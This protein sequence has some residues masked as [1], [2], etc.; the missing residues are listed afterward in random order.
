MSTL[1][2]LPFILAVLFVNT[3]ATAQNIGINT[4]GAVPAASSILDLVSADKGLLIP[5]VALTA[6]NAAAPVTAPATSLLVYNTA[7]AGGAPFNVTPGYYYWDGAQWLRVNAGGATGWTILGNAGTLPTTNFIGTTDAADWV[8][9][10]GGSAATNERARVVAG[11]QVV[12]NNTGLGLNTN[13][14]FSVYGSGTNNGVTLNTS[15]LGLRAINGYTSAGGAAAAWGV[16]GTTSGTTANSFGIVG[17]TTPNTGT[18]NAIRGEAFSVSGPA[19]VGISNTSGGAVPT[20]TATIAVGGQLNGTIAAGT[21]VGIGV[22]GIINPTVATGDARGVYGLSSSNLGTGVWG[23]ANTAVAGFP[24]GTI[25]QVGHE[26]GYGVWGVT[27]AVGA[28]ANPIGVAGE[29]N[30]AIGFGVDGY[31]L[32]AAGTGVLGEGNGLAG[33]YLNT[34][35]G[36]AFSGATNGSFST[37]FTVANGNGVIG[38]GNGT[39][40]AGLL[41]AG[42]SGGTLIG[43]NT[44][45]YGRGNNAVSGTGV[46]GAGNNVVPNVLGTGSGG[47]FTGTGVGSYNVSTTPASGTGVIGVGNNALPA[48]TLAGGSGGAFKGTTTG[49]YG[50]GSTP[51]NGIGVVGV[52]NNTVASIPAVGSGGAFTGATI[53]A[54]GMATTAVGGTGV[55]GAGNNVPTYFTA[56][57]GA[58]GAFT[59]TAT[60][61]FAL[62]TTAGSGTG[63]IAAGNNVPTYFTLTG[64]SGGAFTGTDAGAYAMATTLASGT[65]LI[66]VGNNL[67]AVATLATGSGVAGSGDL[68][69]VYG[70]ATNNAPGAANAPARAGGYFAS[71]AP[72]DAFTY[73]ACL[74]GAGVPRKVMGNG[75]VNTVVKNDRDEYVLLSAPEAPENLFQDY[76]TGQLINGR[77]HVQLDP[78]LSKNILV[79][80]QH[81]IRVF[82]QLR[83][84]CHGVYVANETAEGFDVIEL[85][86][87]TSNAPFYWTVTA[88]RANEVRA[89]GTMWNFAEER[90]ARTMGPQIGRQAQN[91]NAS[92]V[93]TGTVTLPVVPLANVEA[94]TEGQEMVRSKGRRPTLPGR[95]AA[96]E[97]TPALGTEQAK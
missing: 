10:T 37:A 15:A 52:G 57:G 67:P 7:T 38:V 76:G 91:Q 81:P 4:T 14:V 64:G 50:L 18:A 46:V 43:T 28:A 9:K 82:V 42:G 84:D 62:A 3:W 90:F 41:L 93:S 51:A 23:Q 34:G 59:G 5:R 65:G 44:G 27:T 69:G 30:S 86:G 71:G 13:N 6:T 74:E 45:A 47:A 73:V 16:F 70:L 22:R 2:P 12:L 80:E 8:I 33:T 63:V 54:L 89:N 60:G 36:G 35:G 66:G 68:F 94:V 77:T 78:T 21:G 53:G 20:A 55:I 29:A 17:T 24:I 92:S 85:S 49:V 87:G 11:G 96:D 48:A 40:L 72:V 61:A 19:I 58:G 79:N 26:T 56:A 1:R 75:T 39:T 95:T 32:N 88:N 31:N 25:G 83:G 97:P